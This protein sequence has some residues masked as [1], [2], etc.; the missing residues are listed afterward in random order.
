M[1]DQLLACPARVSQRSG[2]ARLLLHELQHPQPSSL[3]L[4]VECFLAHCRTLLAGDLSA[5]PCQLA[6]A[7]PLLLTQQEASP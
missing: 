2:V 1:S 6:T 7:Q 4:V 3:R 5:L